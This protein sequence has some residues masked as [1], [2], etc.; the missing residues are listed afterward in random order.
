MPKK[1][2]ITNQ[3]KLEIALEAKSYTLTQKEIAAKY[4]IAQSQVSRWVAQFTKLGWK[5][6]KT[7]KKKKYFL[8][9]VG[10]ASF[11][12]KHKNR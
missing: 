5:I 6:P 11:H 7:Q 4:N 1:F 9:A 12:Y 8:D 2:A 3:K 10:R